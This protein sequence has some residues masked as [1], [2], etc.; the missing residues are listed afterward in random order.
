MIELEKAKAHLE[1]LEL[2]EAASVL[3]SRLELAAKNQSMYAGFLAD[4]RSGPGEQDT[5]QLERV[6]LIYRFKR[7]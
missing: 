5:S 3:E 6:L 4:P 1:T 7:A 2:S